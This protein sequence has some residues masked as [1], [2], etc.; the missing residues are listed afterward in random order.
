M[1]RFA[2]GNSEGN[3]AGR[4][5]VRRNERP[6]KMGGF[7]SSFDRKPSPGIGRFSHIHYDEHGRKK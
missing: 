6:R 5:T 1:G 4:R 3:T 2:R 7:V